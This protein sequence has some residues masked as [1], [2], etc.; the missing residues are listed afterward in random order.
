MPLKLKNMKGIDFS[1]ASPSSTAI[2]SSTNQ[3]FMVKNT[4]KSLNRLNSYVNDHYKTFTNNMYNNKTH[5]SSSPRVPCISELPFT[6]RLSSSYR[7]KPRKKPSSSI[8][9]HSDVGVG[10]TPRRNSSADVADVR[11]RYYE[12]CSYNSSFSPP[13]SHSSRY[14]LGESKFLDSLSESKKNDTNYSKVKNEYDAWALIPSTPVVI[15]ESHEK[16][17]FGSMLDAEKENK[18]SKRLALVNPN[19]QR[20]IKSSNYDDGFCQKQKSIGYCKNDSLVL[21]NSSGG[22]SRDQVVVLRVSLHCRGCEGKLRKHLS[23]MEGVTSFS[24]DLDTKKVTV[25]GNVTP[26]SV[27]TSISKVK[28]AQFWPSTALNSPS[29]SSSSSNSSTLDFN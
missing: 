13:H 3:H 11:R 8:V 25:I 28:N 14:L 23:K 6:P 10:L 27:L 16:K 4:T 15:D 21:K 1:C 20:V 29:S 5:H 12:K 9:K 24:I 22:R 17:S 18:I 2:C 7:E 26:L 19:D